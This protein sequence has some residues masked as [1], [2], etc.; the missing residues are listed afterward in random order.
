MDEIKKDEEKV[1]VPKSLLETIQQELSNLKKDNEML[2][3]IADK[4]SL[5]NYYS[6]HQQK[7][8]ARVK[9]RTIAIMGEGGEKID[10]IVVGW[11]TIR[12][13]VYKD[14]LTLRWREDQAVKIIFEDGTDV[15]MPLVEW[16][17]RYE[18]KLGT[19]VSKITD[20]ITGELSVKIKKDDDGKEISLGAQYLN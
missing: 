6:R 14:P 20:E 17:R 19:V 11:K 13:E 18:S 8:P 2:L 3:Q 15:D 10:K 16:I 1:E 9:Y 5:G 7:L 4:K 12:D